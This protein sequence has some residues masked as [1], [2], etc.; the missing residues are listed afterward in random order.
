MAMPKIDLNWTFYH[1]G[2][3]GLDVLKPGGV[4][5]GFTLAGADFKQY[6][7][8]WPLFL[9][10]KEN[11]YKIEPGKALY[12]IR[13]EDLDQEAMVADLP[14]LVEAGMQVAETDKGDV[15]FWDEGQEPE[16][17][18]RELEDGQIFLIDLLPLWRETA[19]VT[20]TIGYTKDI[21]KFRQTRG[22]EEAQVDDV[23][24]PEQI[25]KGDKV[26]VT[27][28]QGDTANGT[29]C[30]VRRHRDQELHL[31]PV[32]AKDGNTPTMQ[33]VYSTDP[34]AGQNYGHYGWFDKL[35]GNDSRKE[36]ALAW[37]YKVGTKETRVED[38][39]DQIIQDDFV[40][41]QETMSLAL[42]VR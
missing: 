28:V 34:A 15:G 35:K 12:E 27:F 2:P 19:M 29:V 32:T 21:T 41:T 10:R 30:T 1:V 24:T 5:T 33:L 7:P 20:G 25:Q 3:A 8:L 42:R 11:M 9:S 17:L 40:M 38:L 4:S 14:S 26:L 13:A 22:H 39:I 23:L 37:I 31:L 36:K 6:Y 16:I 18:A